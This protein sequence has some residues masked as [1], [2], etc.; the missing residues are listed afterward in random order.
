[1]ERGTSELYWSPTIDFNPD[2]YKAKCSTLQKMTKF[3]DHH[4]QRDLNTM[5]RIPRSYTDMEGLMFSESRFKS[6]EPFGWSGESMQCLI[7]EVAANIE[8]WHKAG[9]QL[10]KMYLTILLQPLSI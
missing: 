1:M 10:K 5:V 9:T 3:H 6:Y 7:C 8:E 2:D 4:S